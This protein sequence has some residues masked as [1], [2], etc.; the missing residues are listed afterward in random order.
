MRAVG[1][2]P[3]ARAVLM[4]AGTSLFMVLVAWATLIGP[5][6]VFTGP[7]PRPGP[8]TTSAETCL[9]LPVVTNADGSTTEQIPDDINERN[10]CEPPGAGISQYRDLVEQHPPPLWIKVLGWL[11]LGT[12]LLVLAAGTG[13]LLVALARAA[14]SR[15]PE[16]RRLEAEFGVL[17]EPR[18]VAE[19]VVADAAEQDALLL[20]GDARN[21]I[22]ATWHRFEV[23][24]GRAGVP[25]RP[26]ET[27]SE[28]ALR[29]LDLADADIG[30]VTRLAEL[31][32]EARFSDHP[33]TEDHRAEAM[34]ALDA[35]RRSLGVRS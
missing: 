31:Y 19:Q 27:S 25:R 9:P 13:W 35:I 21:A 33:I 4:V 6:E 34:G 7:G 5:D 26:S 3:G 8:G 15:R 20:D 22:V 16:A 11:F 14:F 12:L 30:P 18:A 24:G 32:R 29:L 23:Q 28:Y 10:Y 17:E 1:A 2:S